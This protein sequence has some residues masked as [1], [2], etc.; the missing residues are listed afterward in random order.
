MRSN[1]CRNT[2]VITEVMGSTIVIYFEGD[3]LKPF[4]DRLLSVG[5]I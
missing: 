5:L 2:E 4:F 3:T 1:E